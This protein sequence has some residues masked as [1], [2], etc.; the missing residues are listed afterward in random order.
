[1]VK[2]VGN[3]L[4]WICAG[5]L[6]LIGLISLLV[7][8]LGILGAI[9]ILVGAFIISPLYQ[10]IPY[11]N[12]HP[13]ATIVFG[14]QLLIIGIIIIGIAAGHK[15]E[16]PNRSVPEPV[17]AETTTTTHGSTLDTTSIDTIL[18]P[19]ITTEIVE[20]ETTAE[21]TTL[22]E[23]DITTEE[24]TTTD[25]TTT[26]T[27]VT[28]TTIITTTVIVTTEAPAVTQK[29]THSYVLNTS[30]MKFHYPDCT[31]VGRISSENRSDVEASREDLIA[32]GY[33]PCGRCHP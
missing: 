15:Q 31:S 9:I 21:D 30:T 7:G 2:Q 23:E 32:R 19:E 29:Q 13:I 10:K 8:G 11:L 17:V 14:F 5:F 27:T 33:D 28:T 3:V 26:T 24:T 16:E 6:A 12:G 22:A 4:R 20:S 1:M 25:R 18:S